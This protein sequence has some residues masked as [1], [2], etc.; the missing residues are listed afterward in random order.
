[1]CAVRR[2]AKIL[3]QL[4]ASASSIPAATFPL[5][6]T[7]SNNFLK[8]FPV[9]YAK[10]DILHKSSCPVCVL[11]DITIIHAETFGHMFLARELIVQ[12]MI[13]CMISVVG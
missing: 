2:L 6:E 12:H 1:M 5:P 8:I 7:N 13:H 3:T 11:I 10:F 9:C 4:S